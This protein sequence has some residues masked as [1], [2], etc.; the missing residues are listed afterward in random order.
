[1]H[2]FSPQRK[3]PKQLK[4]LKTMDDT[5]LDTKVFPSILKVTRSNSDK[6]AVTSWGNDKV[7]YDSNQIDMVDL[8]QK[9][10]NLREDPD[11]KK[12]DDFSKFMRG[13]IIEKPESNLEN[14]NGNCSFDSM[15]SNDLQI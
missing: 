6:K 1:M 8:K 7:I 3:N 12:S 2:K 10:K 4:A 9:F 5:L 15:E 13:E 11:K 14:S